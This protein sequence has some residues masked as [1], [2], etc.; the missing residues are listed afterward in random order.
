MHKGIG[1]GLLQGGKIGFGGGL[2]RNDHE[3]A[4]QRIFP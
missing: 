3:I 1:Y 4:S 2:S